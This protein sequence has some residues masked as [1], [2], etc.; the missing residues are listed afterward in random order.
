MGD[1]RSSV[2]RNKSSRTTIPKPVAKA[3]QLEHKD[4][5]VWELIVDNGKIW[6]KVTKFTAK[7]DE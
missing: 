5:I 6:A 7:G 3:L 2:I 1:Y 4:K